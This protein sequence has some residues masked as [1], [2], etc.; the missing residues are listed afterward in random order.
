MKR[1]TL[2]SIILD[3]QDVFKNLQYIPRLHDDSIL[4]DNEIVVISGI[5]RCGK[6]TLLHEIR[7]NNRNKDYFINFDDDRLIHFTVDDFQALLEVFVELFGKQSTFYFDEIQN[8]KGWERFVRR[9]Y[10]QGNKIFITGSNASMLSKELGTHLTGRYYQ[11]ELYPFSFSE[12]LAL[13]KVT[14]S[15]N[16]FYKTETKGLLKNRFNE[17]FKLGG[18]PAYLNFGNRLY[19]K[20]LYESILYRDVMVRNKLTNEQE[21]L[22]L[23]YFLS[24][25]I[26]K[27]ITYNSLSKVINVQNP[28]TVKNYLR[29]LEDTYL[30]FLVNK[31][32]Y[33]LKKQLINPK[34]VY[35][36]DN[37][38]SHVLGF[39]TSEDNGRL[40]E[41]M[42]FIELKRRG[43]EIFYHRQKYECDFLV[44]EKNQIVHAIQVSWSL[45]ESETRERELRGLKEAMEVYNLNAGLILTENDEETVHT[46]QYTIEILPVWRWLLHYKPEIQ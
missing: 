32:D 42:V 14:Y 23:V 10:E 38:L 30:I 27:P 7:Q 1:E 22:E 4:K 12:F 18:F 29:H 17:Y 11:V 13:K 2:I 16:D 20:S 3:Q 36:I 46:D 31:F 25:N 6:S 8:I 40:L 26:A 41:N 39:H 5:R 34:K 43:K 15:L 24:S 37:A 33:A 28:T 9:L 35:L 45:H 19:L 44:R 21:I